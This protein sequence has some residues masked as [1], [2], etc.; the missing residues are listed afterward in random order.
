M[1]GVPTPA[2]SIL[3]AVHN[4]GRWLKPAV[5]SV[6][7][8]T[9]ADLELLVLDNASSDGAVEDLR[10]DVSDRREIGRAHV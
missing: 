10:A 7:N 2:V 3:M 9:F 8:Q 4:A 1:R 5:R 6:L